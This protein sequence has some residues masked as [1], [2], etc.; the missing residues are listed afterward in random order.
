MSRDRFIRGRGLFRPALDIVDVAD[1]LVFD[2]G[3][4]GV[5]G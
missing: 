4:K 3:G 2:G 1:K 5:V